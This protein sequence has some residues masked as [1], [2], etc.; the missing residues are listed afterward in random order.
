MAAPIQIEFSRL[1]NPTVRTRGARFGVAVTVLGLVIY[2]AS[3][4]AGL[5]Q[6]RVFEAGVYDAT[7]ACA[8]ATCLWCALTGHVNRSRWLLIGAALGAWLA[9]DLY[10][11][12]FF[13]GVASPPYP[14]PA[15]AGYL[16]FY[17]LMAGALFIEMRSHDRHLRTTIALDALAGVLIAAAVG[18]AVLYPTLRQ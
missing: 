2:L 3:V 18:A 16:A 14:S 1:Q 5:S 7:I 12:A 8:A 6:K 13:N 10:W 11:E 17:P 4:A 9:G 15:D